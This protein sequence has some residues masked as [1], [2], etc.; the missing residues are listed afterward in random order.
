MRSVLQISGCLLFGLFM[1]SLSAC[2]GS[3][4][5]AG[6][7]SGSGSVALLFTDAPTDEFSEINIT[8]N[9]V[10]LLG[11][12]DAATEIFSG[13]KIINLLDL[14]HHADLFSMTGNVPAGRY[15]KIRLLVSNVELVRKD[16]NGDLIEVIT[17]RLPGNGKIDLNPRG[18]FEV[19][20]D[21][22]LMLEIDFDAR[23]SIQYHTLGKGGYVLRPVIFIKRLA[24]A[25]PGK[26]VRLSGQVSGLDAPA[27]TFRL[28]R[29][30]IVHRENELDS[31]GAVASHV[32]LD[33]AAKWC[34]LVHVTADTALFGPNGDPI[35][36]DDMVNDASV[37]VLGRLE[38]AATN[39]DKPSLTALTVLAGPTG[40]FRKY[41]GVVTTGLDA[42]TSQFSVR[43]AAGQGIAGQD[44]LPVQIQR[45]TTI[46]SRRGEVLDVNALVAGRTVK[47]LGVL[48]L[49]D[50]APD[51]IQAAIIFVDM[52]APPVKLSGTISHI[53]SSPA[54]FTLIADS[55]GDR[56]VKLTEDTAIFLVHDNTGSFFSEQTDATALTEGQSVEAYGRYNLEG[57]LVATT[58]LAAG[59]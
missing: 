11:E 3:D 32:D 28:C 12:N 1:L 27:Q 10:I 39:E 6:A 48:S 49:A 56:C 44:D 30:P 14:E 22:T 52:D 4:S 15:T 9:R 54:G 43:L 23:K 35:T 47:V 37:T 7:A 8:V 19:V 53:D 50:D 26:L 46:V 17:P 40:T 57:C 25:T 59:N 21:Q 18:A 41:T 42:S 5:T 55:V 34:P 31:D 24:H 29:T 33:D 2:G 36:F 38:H 45:G 13:E 16:A 51:V 58:V 20:A